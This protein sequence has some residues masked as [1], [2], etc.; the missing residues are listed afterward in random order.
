MGSIDR[1]PYLNDNAIL[2]QS[3]L[4]ECSG[5]LT[6]QL[7][8]ICI[9]R[10]VGGGFI[11]MFFSDRSKY[12]KLVGASGTTFFEPRV[13][14][15]QI[16][17]TLGDFLSNTLE[18]SSLQVT[19][20]NSDQ[21]FNTIM[22]GGDLYNGFI[23]KELEVL[24]GIGENGSNYHT[25]FNGQIT[26][27]GGFSRDY[28]SF[29]LTAKNKFEL[30][31][32]EFPNE[33]LLKSEFPYLDD[34]LEGTALPLV[35]GDWTV[36]IR[37]GAPSVPSFA[38]NS[39]DPL[40]NKSI[41]NENN[42][43]DP[44]VGSADIL[45]LISINPLSYVNTS[46]VVLVRSDTAYL[47]PLG[48]VAIFPGLDNR[49]IVI[50]QKG[51]VIDGEPFIYQDG[52]EFFFEVMGT[53]FESGIDLS[54]PVRQAKYI[55]NYYADVMDSELD[56]SWNTFILRVAAKGW[57][58][59]C[60]IKDQQPLLEYV[61]SF[62]EQ[63][64]LEVYINN[65]NKLA[66]T[67]LWFEDF[68]PNPSF[69]LNNWDIIKG[70]FQPR[71]EDRNVFNSAKAEYSFDPS[72]TQ[73]RFSTAQYSNELAVTQMGSKIAKLI[74]FPN[75]Y[76]ESHVLE[77]LHEILRLVP[78]IEYI[79]CSVIPR[80]LLLE[81]GQHIGLKINI[82]GFNLVD[83][84]GVLYNDMVTGIVRSIG[85]DPKGMAI[86]LKIWML[87]MVT[88]PGSLKNDVVGKISGYNVVITKD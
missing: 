48:D 86:P 42:E 35:L 71:L 31:N 37:R 52:D 85:F 47:V 13:T 30:L 26:K 46:N 62:F 4:D 18:L 36:N 56:A 19:I 84:F 81:L 20:N 60:W 80:A 82:G 67:S 3:L 8:M 27:V 2:T 44:N 76:E 29:Q 38:V 59:R 65:E 74:V 23:N 1:R 7:E 5:N 49:G 9:V 45:V 10:D 70:T 25:I 79:E 73:N 57:K 88:F 72:I 68:I 39:Q 33:Y 83:K 53:T 50:S 75:L 55:L 77:N 15:P 24:V 87:Q 14:F 21:Y 63:I 28:K 41:V 16:S 32:T 22:P 6:T 43:P 69:K 34:S 12:V 58:T 64:R 66:I 51:F 54:N 78:Y 61:L 11:N 40:V 17:R